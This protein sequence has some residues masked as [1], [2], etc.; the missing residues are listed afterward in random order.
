MSLGEGG[1]VRTEGRERER[2]RPLLPGWVENTGTCVRGGETEREDMASEQ[3]W[4][5]R[6]VNY[7]WIPC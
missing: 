4:R 1:S 3:W 2:W 7:M 6:Q 5:D